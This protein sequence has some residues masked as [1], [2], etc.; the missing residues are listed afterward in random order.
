MP[1]R[2]RA[3]S[4]FRPGRIIIPA[5]HNDN[6][7]HWPC[8]V[9]QQLVYVHHHRQSNPAMK[10]GFALKLPLF[11]QSEKKFPPRQSTYP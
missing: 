2:S 6:E 10:G 4:D 8:G 11:G 9:T 7:A 3:Y 1:L 5:G